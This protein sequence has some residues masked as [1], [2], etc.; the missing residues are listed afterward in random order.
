MEYNEEENHLHQ[1]NLWNM[2]EWLRMLIPGHQ[3]RPIK[4]DL[5]RPWKIYTSN[6]LLN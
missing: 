6:E 3:P 5:G 1:I 4:S 2:G